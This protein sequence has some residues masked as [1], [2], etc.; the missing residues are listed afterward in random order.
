MPEPT[1]R[2]RPASALTLWSTEQILPEGF[3]PMLPASAAG[4]LDSTDH[5]YEVRWDGARLLVGWEGKQQV[6]RTGAG[7]DLSFWLPELRR[8]R[9]A[10]DPDWVLLDGE[11]IVMS[12]E[13]KP[14]P[15]LLQR[16]LRAP[17]AAAVRKVASETPLRYVVYD[18]LRIGDSWLLDVTWEERRDILQRAVHN[19]GLIQ[20]SPVAAS[21]ER[22][23]GWASDLGLDAVVAKRLRGRY[24]PGERTRDW[25][26]IK[27]MEVVETVICGWTEGKGVR[28][29][30]LGTLVL[31][32]YESDQLVYAG[33]TG[34]GMDGAS[35][36][37]LNE[38]V[39][40]MPS[41]DCPFLQEPE[42]PAEVRWV[43][44]TLVCRVRHPGWTAAG[45]MRTPTFLGMVEG[46]L[47]RNCL[48]PERTETPVAR[49]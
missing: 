48:R 7:Q 27:P 15:T 33:H 42:T 9:S 8:G 31:G 34:T 11:V 37:W 10:V 32:L 41:T 29:G 28:E 6:L 47:P 25:L 35:L 40:A 4:P 12:E 21:G 30:S 44:P 43:P 39:R 5:A 26:S 16:R 13:G 20:L 23:I 19:T 24:T 38:T 36:R 49:R 45:S 14:S 46:G 17:D 3:L 2:E 22:A 1:D 18:I